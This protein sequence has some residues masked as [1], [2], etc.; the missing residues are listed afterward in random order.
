[1]VV[2]SVW[3]VSVLWSVSICVVKT[4]RVGRID[5]VVEE[6]GVSGETPRRDS[7]IVRRSENAAI[8]T[9]EDSGRESVLLRARDVWP[10]CLLS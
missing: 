9:I 1:M 8:A 5:V 10:G 6:G 7:S 3:G 4:L 2:L